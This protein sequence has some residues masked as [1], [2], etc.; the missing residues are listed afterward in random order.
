MC[1]CG[2]WTWTGLDR[3]NAFFLIKTKLSE[4]VTASLNSPEVHAELIYYV[5]LLS[6]K[7]FPSVCDW[8][9]VCVFNLR[10]DVSVL[11]RVCRA[12]ATDITRCG[13]GGLVAKPAVYVRTRSSSQKF[14]ADEV[15]VCL[16][17]W[18]QTLTR[19]QPR[20]SF[21]LRC[22]LRPL[23]HQSQSHAAN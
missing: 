2:S 9:Q 20:A 12:A 6:S 3:T 4:S 15:C 21:I 10:A 23:R 16:N 7:L 22:C 14:G 17:R 13:K 8:Q 5:C 19:V 18:M 11:L 1:E